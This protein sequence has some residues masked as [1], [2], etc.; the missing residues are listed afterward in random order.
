MSGTNQSPVFVTDST[1]SRLLE[2]SVSKT[3]SLQGPREPNPIHVPEQSNSQKLL[4]T[5][6]L[7][8][9]WDGPDDPHNP[10]KCV[11]LPEQHVPRAYRSRTVGVIGANGL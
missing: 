1:E 10:K 2:D 4:P 3:P 8:V 6:V 7:I 9:D 11:A 5:D